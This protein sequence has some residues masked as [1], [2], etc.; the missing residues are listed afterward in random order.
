MALPNDEQM[1]MHSDK[2]RLIRMMSFNI[3]G[4]ST[5]R[6]RAAPW[7]SRLIVCDKL[8]RNHQPDVIGFQEVYDHNQMGLDA[9]LQDY[10]I[11][12]GYSVGTDDT[13]L[14]NPIYWRTERFNLLDKI[15]FYL[16]ERPSQRAIGWDAQDIRVATC[17]CL[18]CRF[19][20]KRILYVNVHLDHR[21]K[22]ARMNSTQQILNFVADQEK[23]LRIDVVIV[24]GD[25][26]TRPWC[27]KDEDV[28]TYPPP[29]LPAYL[30]DCHDVYQSLLDAS[31]VD[32]YIAGGFTNQLD[33]NTYHD[34]F[35]ANFPSV[36]LRL[37]WIMIRFSQPQMSIV[38]YQTVKSELSGIYASDHYAIAATIRLPKHL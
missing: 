23:H 5:G 18:Q 20:L 1:Q 25:F 12:N 13:P 8:L 31:F 3:D 34:Y 10:A 35:G 38:G 27:P 37:D 26:N 24:A 14:Y 22:Q 17:L 21:G 33:M 28:Y 2:H 32:A 30:P 15:S 9:C 4:D 7:Q 19:T 6:V 36:A 11:F 16:S 29:I